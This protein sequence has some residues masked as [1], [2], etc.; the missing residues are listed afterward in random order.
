MNKV[1]VV[2]SFATI[3][4]LL[5]FLIA[6]PAAGADE[7]NQATKV[8]FDQPIQIPGRV[9]P[10]G[11]YWFILPQDVTQHYLVRIFNSDRTTQYATLFTINAERLQSTG[12]T[13]F[14]FA[15]VVSVDEVKIFKPAPVVYELAVKMTGVNKSQIGFVSSNFWDAAGGKTFGFQTHWI[16]RA[17][18]PP[19]EL[20]ILPDVTLKSLT[21]L[22][23]LVA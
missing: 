13:T 5:A 8:T 23:D 18:A 12:H 14:I 15:H 4:L 2:K 7:E 16:N 10:A 3:A 17:A 21:D 22:I 1:G 6:L 20:G 11:T 19:D 9:L